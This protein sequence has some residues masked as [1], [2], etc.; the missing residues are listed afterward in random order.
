MGRDVRP[1]RPPALTV[2]SPSSA[3]KLRNDRRRGR[4]RYILCSFFLLA[5]LGIHPAAAQYDPPAG[6]Y[7]SAEGLTGPALKAA[8]HDIID[9]HTIIASDGGDSFQALRTLDE[10]PNDSSRVLTVYSG[11]SELKFADGGLTWNRE[12]CWPRGY[13]ISATG[14]GA[15]ADES[16]LFNLRPCLSDVNTL[17]GDRIYDNASTNHPTDPAVAPPDA[18]EC[19]Y[20]ANRGQGEIWTPRPS[21]KGDLARAMFYMAVR[22]DGSDPGSVDLELGESAN[23]SQAVFGNLTTLLQW[24][25]DDPV[26]TE[27]RRRNDLIHD[28]YQGNRNPFVDRPEFVAKIFGA[29]ELQIVL[30]RSAYDEG[31]SATATVSLPSVTSV[32]LN[33]RI[34]ATGDGTEISAPSVVTIPAGQ[35]S[36]EF[37]V[38]FL[39][40]GAADGD[41][42]AGLAAWADGYLSTFFALAVLDVNGGPV[43]TTPVIAGPGRYVQNFDTLPSAGTN[44]WSNDVTL[45]GWL[46]Q[47]TGTGTN[48]VADAGS[49]TAG[50]LYSYGVTNSAERALGSIGSASP[51]DLTW[52]V[53]LQ[54]TSGRTVTLA[55][56]AYVGEQ[57]RNSAAAAQS[58]A[59][60]YRTGSNAVTDLQ[61]NNSAGWT[62]FSAL[63]FTSPVTGGT[64]SALN[65]NL[66][67]NRAT[68]Q[69]AFD[70]TLAPG[71]WI[72][73]RWQD[74]DHSGSDHGLAIDDLRLDWRVV[75]EGPKPLWS[76]VTLPSGR[77]GESYSGLFSADGGVIHYEA[78]GLPAGLSVGATDGALTGAPAAAGNYAGFAYAVNA[79]GAE[80]TVFTLVVAKGIPV[81]V[82]P[83]T[84]SVV[85]PGQPLSAVTLTGGAANVPGTFAFASPSTIPPAGVAPQTVRFTPDD[86]DKYDIVTFSIPVTVDYGSGF[87]DVTK[88]GYATGN[89][90]I[91]GIDWEFADALIA[92]GDAND[93]KNGLQSVRLRGYGTSALTM[94][95]DLSGGIGSITFDHR[96]YGTDTQIA[97]IVEYSTDQGG[98]WT[99]A[100]RFTAG[101]NVATFSATPNISTPARLRIRAA[102]ATGTSNRR[103][104]IDDLVITAYTAPASMTFGQWSGGLERTPELIMAYAIGGATNAQ[105]A[106]Q[107]PAYG[108]TGATLSIEALVRTN[109]PTLRVFAQASTNLLTTAGWSTN[110]VTET[111]VA[112]QPGDPADTARRVFSV[113]QGTDPAK[114]LRLRIQLDE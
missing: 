14:T 44:P 83:P 69:S 15:S 46:A 22:Y 36:A 108:F 54:N 78:T 61:P 25:L 67:A 51:G 110:D 40:D 31:T 90:A 99:E 32:A 42:V 52:A 16:D 12:H 112:K 17:R 91:A 29:P 75:A 43:A 59:F 88:A 23:A 89:V 20:D 37:T 102:M 85:A 6:Y 2:A 57:W 13:G 97:W 81:I 79:A 107:A 82:T 104:N 113:P 45:A 56:L 63:N 73:L 5:L 47:R 76:A 77:V 53:N 28:R 19:L 18:P 101:E 87:E 50:N 84:A 8:L 106:G 39:A 35:A 62:G 65:G 38:N 30:D 71:E 58:V 11:T 100:G 93:F 60:S 66:P 92:S 111:D 1:A 49:S 68:V 4:R 64:A 41:Q 109:D 3:T 74:P 26:S 80:R 94:L 24:H 27:E 33:I 98:S 72:T 70:V 34:I 21:E 9:D 55:S 95:A 48:I 10:D 96:R 7:A 86:T 105:S 114:F 103:T